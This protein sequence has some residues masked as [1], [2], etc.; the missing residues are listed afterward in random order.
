MILRLY[1]SDVKSQRDLFLNRTI[2]NLLTETFAIKIDLGANLMEKYRKYFKFCL[3]LLFTV[4]SKI[5]FILN[6]SRIIKTQSD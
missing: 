5:K 2:T 6:Q 4:N 3:L 1:K